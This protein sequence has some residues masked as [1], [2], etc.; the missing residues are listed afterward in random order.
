[1]TAAPFPRGQSATR[2]P[3]PP[4]RSAAGDAYNR[5]PVFGLKSSS[6]SLSANGQKAFSTGWIAYCGASDGSPPPVLFRFSPH[7]RC[8]SVL[9]FEPIGGAPRTVGRV[10]PLRDDTFKPHLAGMGEEGRAVAFNMFIEPDVRAG[11]GHDRCECGLAD[12][13]RIAPQ[14][15]AVQFDQV[16]GVQEYAVVSAVVP[17]EIERGN[18]VVIAGDSFAIDN[19]GARA[20]AGQ[21][22]DDQREAAGEVVAGT[23][24]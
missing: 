18:A 20:Q 16:E 8:V 10:L 9:H 19:P 21:R 14:V 13:K 12:L 23:A 15:V 5:A 11:L 2:C 4:A 6:F 24:V 22:L 1:M 17:D 7:R 3:R